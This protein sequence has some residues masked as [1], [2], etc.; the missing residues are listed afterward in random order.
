MLPMCRIN[1]RV[2]KLRVEDECLEAQADLLPWI[3]ATFMLP[4]VCVAQT[5]CPVGTTP[6]SATCGLSG[7]GEIATQPR[8]IGV[9]NQDLGHPSSDPVFRK[10]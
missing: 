4:V 6:V 5:A 2:C 9:V 1:P 7:V 10:F 3:V 8:P